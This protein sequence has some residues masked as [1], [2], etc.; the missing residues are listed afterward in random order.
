M[1]MRSVLSL[2]NTSFLKQLTVS[3]VFGIFCLSLLSSMGIFTLSYRIVRERWIAQGMRATEIFADQSTLALLYFS[4]ENAEAPVR[5]ILAFPD[6]RGV[7]IYGV[8]RTLLLSSGEAMPEQQEWPQKLEMGRETDR[9]WYFAAPVFARR[10]ASEDASPFVA[11]PHKSELIGFVRLAMGKE[12][13]RDMQKG[14]LW[15]NVAVSGGFAFLFLLLLLAMTRRLTTPLNRLANIMGQASAGAKGVRAEIRGPRDIVEMEIAFNTMMARIQ[16]REDD[17]QRLTLFQRAILDNAAYGIISTT[18]DGVVTS[19]NRAAELLLGY[20]AGEVV[21]TLTP[22]SWHD[23]EEIVRYALVLSGE[24]GEPITP[25]FE[26]FAARPRRSL[27]EE[28]EWTFIRKDGT[29]VPV[30][31]SVTALWDENGCITGFVGLTYDLT[32]R[33][34]AEEALHSQTIELE[35]EV[36]ER[37]MAQ[38]HLQEKAQL[39]E[40]EIDKR[41]WAQ[42]ELEQFNRSL[43]QRVRER[44]AELVAKSTELELKNREL[45][46]FN[47]LFVNRELKMVEL[48]ERIKELERKLH[49]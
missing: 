37:Q 40:E 41:Q 33:R 38:E 3:F 28:N 23:Q 31:L 2:W 27:P 20:T 46:R 26:V 14:I 18:P 32:E 43:E 25:G 21:G 48:K 34:K 47:K 10:G 16:E 19:F 12:T 24:L 39:L 29:R 8:D 7:A 5:S 36:A 15:I 11:E 49:A 17:L 1:K 22:A 13:L 30:L 4:P 42:A 45:E 6:V 35:A 44:A 9:A